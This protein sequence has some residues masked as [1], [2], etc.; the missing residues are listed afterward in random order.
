MISVVFHGFA[1]HLLLIVLNHFFGVSGFQH[2]F[3]QVDDSAINGFHLSS[4]PL[5]I[6]LRNKLQ[7]S[8]Y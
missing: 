4:S 1:S 8:A 3:A 7:N 2:I 5:C 6:L